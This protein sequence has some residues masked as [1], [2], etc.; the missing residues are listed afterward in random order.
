M[1]DETRPGLDFLRQ[2]V[3]DDMDSGR[4]PPPVTTRF[5]PEP[6]GYLHIGHAKA[7]CLDF[8]IAEEWQGKT[9]LRF[10]DTNP[11]KEDVEFVD[12]IKR[13]IHWL[14]FDWEDREFFASDYFEQLYQWA[15]QLISK[16]LAYVD[17][18]SPEEISKNRGTPTQAG[19]ES[20]YRTRTVEENLELFQ[21]MRDGKFPDGSCVLRAKIDMA[22]PNLNMRDPVM[23]RIKHAHH[24]RTGDA[25]CIY[26]MYDWAHGQSDAI[27]GITH[28]MCTLEFENHRPLYNWYLE[29][30]ELPNPPRQIEFN[31]LNLTYTVLSKRKLLELV[32]KN[33]V[34]GWNDPRMPTISGIRRRG[35]PAGAIRAFVGAMG[36]SK[37][38]GMVDLSALEYYVREELNR[39]ARRVMVVLDPVKV[40]ITN[41]PEG[42]TEQID[43]ENNP[44]DESA[45]WRTIPFSRELFIE[46]ADFMEAPPKKYFR[47]SP[48]KE[49]RLKHAYFITCQEVIKDARGII[50]EL[51]CTYDP[52][53]RGGSSPDGRKVK[54]TLH[55]VSCQ[56]SVDARVR[57]YDNLFVKPDMGT[58]EEGKDYLDY[59]NPESL[60]EVTAK[61]EPCMTDAKAGE[62]YQFL[63]NGY[64]TADEID[65]LPQDGTL[66]FNRTV[67]LKDSWAKMERKGQTN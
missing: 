12:S 36:V 38:E 21:D 62:H 33:I 29:K 48:G 53:S 31:R 39:T 4:F 42:K 10:D 61:A 27:E 17:S 13:D 45:G 8:G 65:H 47:L 50:T 24:H 1:S 32:Q 16:G 22:H 40:V 15:Q 30:L 43:A 2:T 14:G 44:E 52:E 49:V 59:L 23:Y 57:L 18:Q 28:S 60:V 46:R 64:F 6:N 41:Y 5:P 67:T 56:E 20:P 25:W 26:P 9:N 3:K 11:T 66:V 55:W 58:L 54:G 63:R 51:R 37:T 35:Y 7:I 19:I 34:E